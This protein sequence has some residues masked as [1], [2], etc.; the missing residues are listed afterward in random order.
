VCSS[1]LGNDAD[2]ALVAMLRQVNELYQEQQ[3]AAKS[4]RH[5]FLNM[6]KARQ[7]MGPN[8]LSALDCRE[9]MRAQFMLNKSAEVD[10]IESVADLDT[11]RLWEKRQPG[12]GK[13][14]LAPVLRRR[15]GADGSDEG[16]AQLGTDSE[17]SEHDN[18]D[19]ERDPILLFGSMI[20][21]ALRRAKNDF[22][23]AL[24]HYISAANLAHK[25]SQAERLMHEAQAKNPGTSLE[26]LAAAAM[27][28][29]VA[30]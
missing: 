8:S 22:A 23:V 20:P 10:Y 21:P 24:E 16:A 6:A 11:A 17:S 18:S 30:P 4:M 19:G 7:S 29:T 26:S 27:E 1:D 14:S 9:H 12:A 3:L 13:G 15:A 2:D 5:G 28:R 25:I